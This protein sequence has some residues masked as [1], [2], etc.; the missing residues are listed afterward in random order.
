MHSPTGTQTHSSSDGLLTQSI[1]IFLELGAPQSVTFTPK[2]IILIH[3]AVWIPF[4]KWYIIDEM[5]KS[6]T[7]PWDIPDVMLQDIFH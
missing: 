6:L 1:R 2:C 7:E 5:N 4:I 3:H